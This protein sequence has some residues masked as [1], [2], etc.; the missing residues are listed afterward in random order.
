MEGVSHRRPEFASRAIFSSHISRFWAEP[1]RNV[2][3]VFLHLTKT[4]LGLTAEGRGEASVC[5]E[6]AW[7]KI[8][9]S[10]V[11]PVLLDVAPRHL[12]DT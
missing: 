4:S 5:D 11:D 12:C 10:N 3:D 8:E 2:P 1:Q 6:L 9:N 7:E